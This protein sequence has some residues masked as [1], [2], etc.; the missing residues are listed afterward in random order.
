VGYY[1]Y[2]VAFERFQLGYGAALTLVI[3]LVTLAVAVMQAR[4]L[5]ER[6]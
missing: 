4:L 3:M 2:E 1:L 6:R 5:G